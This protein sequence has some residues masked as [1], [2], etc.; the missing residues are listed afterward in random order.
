VIADGYSPSRS[1]TVAHGIT[2]QYTSQG[3]LGVTQGGRICRPRKK[4][5]KGWLS[6][7]ALN[8]VVSEILMGKLMSI[9]LTVGQRWN[10]LTNR[11]KI[12]DG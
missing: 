10:A 7:V 8:A 9:V 11:G 1:F 4:K 3:M 2:V 6:I 5:W 12:K